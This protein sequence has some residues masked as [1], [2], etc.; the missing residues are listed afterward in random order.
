MENGVSSTLGRDQAISGRVGE[1][2]GGC[3]NNRV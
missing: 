3:D 1:V 2:G